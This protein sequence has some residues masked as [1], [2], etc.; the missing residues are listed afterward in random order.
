MC[1]LKKLL[2]VAVTQYQCICVLL[3][4]VSSWFDYNSSVASYM[5]IDLWLAAEREVDKL[6]SIV[7]KDSAYS[8]QENTEDYDELLECSPDTEAD[9]IIHIRGS[10][11]SFVDCLDDEFTRVCKIEGSHI[12]RVQ[13]PFFY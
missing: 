8:I 2:E 13:L 9:S 12:H 5:P 6:I 10:I 11:I 4:L 1:I 3:A 7:A